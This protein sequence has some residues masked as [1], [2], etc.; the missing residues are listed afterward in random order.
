MKDQGKFV[1]SDDGKK[2]F[3]LR[4]F[5]IATCA[6]LA[7]SAPAHSVADA[8]SGIHVRDVVV[9]EK[10]DELLVFGSL[11]GAFSPKL[12]EAIHGGVTGSFI[13]DISLLQS[14]KLIHDVE[15]FARQLSHRVKY[16]ALKKTYTFLVKE[17]GKDLERKVTDSEK[18]MMTWMLELNG[19]AIASEKALSPNEQ[20]YVRIR[21]RLKRVDF[22]FP[23]NYLLSFLEK[24]SAWNYSETFGLKGM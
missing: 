10:N 6:F 14:R 22:V 21:A 13:F 17:N 2:A 11:R 3:L 9:V 18:E 23:F 19:V 5:T 15:V 20:Y 4:S 8:Q 12:L 16:S 24:K 7:L 1:L